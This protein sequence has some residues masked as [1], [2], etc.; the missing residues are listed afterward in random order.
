[1]TL[2]RTYLALPN[3]L[4]QQIR[5]IFAKYWAISILYDVI[6]GEE[7]TMQLLEHVFRIGD[8]RDEDNWHKAAM[9]MN[10]KFTAKEL[11]EII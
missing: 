7:R 5:C 3:R 9:S 6:T 8:V 11:I 10:M 4:H 1:M 2:I